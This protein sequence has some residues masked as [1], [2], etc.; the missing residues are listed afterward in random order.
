L[1]VSGAVAG[2][3]VHWH[4]CQGDPARDRDDEC[5]VAAREKE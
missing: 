5:S 4:I 2:R 1:Q 3:V